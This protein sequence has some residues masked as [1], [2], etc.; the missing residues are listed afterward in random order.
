MID[1]FWTDS[2]TSLGW[3]HNDSQRQLLALPRII[4]AEIVAVDR[5]EP[6]VIADIGSGP[7]DF[8]AVFLE[9]F[10]SARGLWRDISEPL[11]DQART[12]LES[13]SGRVEFTIVDMT[14]FAGLPENVDVIISSRALHHLD[15]DGLHE[16]YR[17]AAD[18]L[19]AG[20][21]LIN[22]DHFGPSDVWNTRLREARSRLIPRSSDQKPHH[23]NYPL[24]SVEDHLH[25]LD[26]AGFIDVETP[27]R[28]FVTALFMARR[29]NV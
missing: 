11:R 26:A 7:G 15:R 29:D 4:A 9:R 5:P 21:W 10:P 2:A 3:A 17:N 8:L 13:Y 28:G 6:T 23:H 19:A 16:F 18:H 27:W 20:G 12:A 24:T 14:D 1:T 25:A 22:L